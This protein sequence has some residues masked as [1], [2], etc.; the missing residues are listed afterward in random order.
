MR[1]RVSFILALALALVATS[2]AAH[3]P[4]APRRWQPEPR[5]TMRLQDPEGRPLRSFTHHGATFVL[6]EMGRRYDIVVDN[7]GPRRV[8]VV[9]SVDGRDVIHGERSRGSLDRGYVVPGRGSVVIRGFRTSLEE[10][11]AFRFSS[12]RDSFAGRH[13][14]VHRLGVITAQVF[15]ERAAKRKP[16]AIADRHR[17]KS[18]PPPRSSAAPAPGATGRASRR[19]VPRPRENNLGTEFGEATHSEVREVSFERAQPSPRQL[20]SL[21]YDDAP[22]LAARGIAVTPEGGWRPRPI[23]RERPVSPLSERGE[24]R[25]RFAQ[26]PPSRLSER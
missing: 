16:V 4:S 12:P 11:A 26:P 7:P 23:P 17:A 1:I 9:V 15:D 3:P 18:A 21:R 13:G 19:P 5:V 20:L 25:R 22:G 8:E 14:E 6:G 2:A 24:D 10:V